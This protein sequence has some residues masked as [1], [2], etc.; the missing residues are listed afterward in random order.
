[1]RA[2]ARRR[3]V[4]FLRTDLSLHD[5]LRILWALV[6]LWYEAGVYRYRLFRCSWPDQ[7]LDLVSTSSPLCLPA[8]NRSNGQSP[9][10]VESYARD[11]RSAGLRPAGTISLL[12]QAR[13][14][15]SQGP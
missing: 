3:A 13:L 6:V 15:L 2:A 4:A 10:P 9:S 8:K 14:S 5:L 1:M 12:A 11:A 7:E